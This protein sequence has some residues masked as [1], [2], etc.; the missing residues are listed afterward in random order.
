MKCSSVLPGHTIAG[1]RVEAVHVGPCAVDVPGDQGP[2]TIEAGDGELV[3]VYAPTDEALDDANRR[4]A[5][6]EAAAQE[7]AATLRA[8]LVND[9]LAAFDQGPDE[10]HARIADVVG[11][12][13]AALDTPTIQPAR[14]SSVL[15][16]DGDVPTREERAARFDTPTL[17]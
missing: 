12:L 8:R 3:V 16:A 5:A 14:T 4:R 6:L 9:V 2:V 1:N 17:A 7:L 15:L 13:R 11:A 10:L